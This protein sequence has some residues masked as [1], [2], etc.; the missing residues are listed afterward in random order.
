MGFHPISR[1]PDDF[2]LHWLNSL[3]RRHLGNLTF[4]EVRKAVQALSSLYVERRQRIDRG[5]AFDSAGKRAAFATYFGPLHFLLVREIVRALGAL[6]PVNAAIL[7]FGCGTGV[8]GTAWALESQPPSRVIG[9]DRNAW[10]VQECRS[11]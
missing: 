10:A 4:Q 2:F 8:A 6:V 3:Q 1:F 11:T 9:V 7:D 5:S